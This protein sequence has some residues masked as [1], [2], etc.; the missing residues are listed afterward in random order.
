MFKSLSQ[1]QSKINKIEFNWGTDSFIIL[2]NYVFT[3]GLTIEEN[4]RQSKLC[5]I[6]K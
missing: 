5:I 1:T 6:Y 2:E 4:I 3:N